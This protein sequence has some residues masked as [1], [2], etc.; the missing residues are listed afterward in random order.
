MFIAILIAILIPPLAP[1][2]FW[3]WVIL[4]IIDKSV[5]LLNWLHKK[6]EQIPYWTGVP[7]KD[8]IRDF[9]PEQRKQMAKEYEA[10]LL[11]RSCN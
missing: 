5:D 4:A 2:L 10:Y 3:M 8:G 6:F 1:L 7:I 9:T 11:K